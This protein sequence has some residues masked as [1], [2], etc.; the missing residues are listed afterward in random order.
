MVLFKIPFNNLSFS[1]WS[2]ASRVQ[3]YK[4]VIPNAPIRGRKPKAD[5][6]MRQYIHDL[7]KITDI[8]GKRLN[9]MSAIADVVGMSKSQVCAILKEPEHSGRWYSEIDGERRYY[10]D[11]KNAYADAVDRKLNLHFQLG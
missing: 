4:A 5:P 7:Y 6:E 11:Y 8:D 1:G 2:S 9:S 10:E 3:A